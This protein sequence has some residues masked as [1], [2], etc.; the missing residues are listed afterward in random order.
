MLAIAAERLNNLAISSPRLRPSVTQHGANG[1]EVLSHLLQL[2]A[3]QEIDMVIVMT[4][5]EADVALPAVGVIS[6]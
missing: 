3:T 1:I 5:I 4:Q 2:V 6:V